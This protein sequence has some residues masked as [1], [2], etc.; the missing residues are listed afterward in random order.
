MLPRM[1][2]H[3]P[4]GAFRGKRRHFRRTR[5]EAK[6]ATEEALNGWCNLWHYHADWKGVGNRRWS[7]RKKHIRVLCTVFRNILLRSNEVWVTCM[8]FSDHGLLASLPL[9]VG[10]GFLPESLCSVG[11]GYRRSNSAN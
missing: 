9:R 4:K 11:G 5:R 1:T 10:C 3:S 6:A 8:G 7:Y 2:E